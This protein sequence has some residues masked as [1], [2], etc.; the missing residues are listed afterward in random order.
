MKVLILASE[1][2]PFIKSGGLGDVTGSLPHALASKG[3]DVSVFIP[4]YNSINQ[5][6]IKDA[7]YICSTEVIIGNN[8]HNASIYKIVSNNVNVY[9]VKN[10]H[11]FDRYGLYGFD[12]DIERYTFF[13]RA[14]LCTLEIL[15]YKPDII[16]L[17]DWQTGISAL[18]LK[19]KFKDYP[20]YKNIKTLIT[21]HNIQY[22]GV[23][24]EYRY[25]ALGI[26]RDYWNPEGVEYYNKINLLKTGLKFA[27]AISTVSPTYSNE[28][29]TEHFGYGLDGVIRSRSNDSYG[30]LNGIDYNQLNTDANKSIY[31]NDTF[32][33]FELKSIRKK[34]LQKLCGLPENDVPVYSVISRLADQKGLDLISD[35]IMYKDIQ[36]IILGTGDA[37]LEHKFIQLQERFPNKVKAF[38]TFDVDLSNKIYAGSDFFLMPSLFEPCGLGQIFAMNFG[39]LPIVRNTGGLADTVKHYNYK[40]QEGNGIV[41]NDFLTSALNWAIEEGL[42]LYYNKN[43]FKNAV[44]NARNSSFSWDKSAEQYINLYKQII[45]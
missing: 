13:N 3:V 8:T 7:S 45:S 41:F 42:Q 14:A 37:R 27:D 44:N 20:F 5:N 19:D 36:F 1:M 31:V 33:F 30:I 24:P 29:M 11:Y 25:Y 18:Y 43:N 4:M 26:S 34:E 17:N 38:I 12:D 28:I 32:D 9:F 15:N 39:T 40:T 21:I 6:T 23:F 2:A 16:H 35:N 10:Q 22:Q